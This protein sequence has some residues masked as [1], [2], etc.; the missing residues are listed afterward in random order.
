MGRIG[1]KV[2]ALVMVLLLVLT[3][4]C[5][6]TTEEITPT[7]DEVSPAPTAETGVIEIRVTDPPAPQFSSIVVFIDPIEGVKVHKVVSGQSG[8]WIDVPLVISSFDLVQL[9]GITETLGA[10]QTEA[11]RFTQIRI[12]VEAV[13]VDGQPATLPSDTLK[14]VR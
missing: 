12:A 6:P 11:G 4:A 14:I 8:E 1:K 2:A 3:V 13:E 5:T 9:V 10:V 7:T